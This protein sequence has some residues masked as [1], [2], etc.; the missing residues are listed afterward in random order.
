MQCCLWQSVAAS[1]LAGRKLLAGVGFRPAAQ[2]YSLLVGER[3]VEPRFPLRAPEVKASAWSMPHH[4]PAGPQRSRFSAMLDAPMAMSPRARLQYSLEGSSTHGRSG[5][6]LH[7]IL[8]APCRATDLASIACDLLRAQQ[9][10]TRRV[11]A[12]KGAAEHVSLESTIELV[13][14]MIGAVSLPCVRVKD[15]KG[16][17]MRQSYHAAWTDGAS[18]VALYHPD[19]VSLRQYRASARAGNAFCALLT[20]LFAAQMQ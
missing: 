17:Y 4:F 11:C 2:I 20:I 18:V 6:Q 8:A 1:D 14:S 13:R 7:A 15:P 10:L 16:F 3:V 12:A 5:A 19:K 9:A